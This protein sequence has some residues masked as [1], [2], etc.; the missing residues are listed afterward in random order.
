VI[1]GN[2]V[3]LAPVDAALLV[4][5]LEIVG[6]GRRDLAVDAGR[7]AERRGLADLD[8]GIGD[9]RHCGLLRQRREGG[10]G[11]QQRQGGSD[12][13]P[14]LHLGLP[15]FFVPARLW[16]LAAIGRA[17]RAARPGRSLGQQDVFLAVEPREPHGLERAIVGRAGVHRDA[18]QQHGEADVVHVGGGLHDVLARQVV[19]GILQHPYEGFGHVVAVPGGGV[20]DLV[21]GGVFLVPGVERLHA[22]IIL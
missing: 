2:E 13:R 5:H 16:T 9:A 10:G 20:G 21:L 22:G 17:A 8:L 14:F 1:E 15:W 3:D 4:Y 19:A 11:Q 18:R 12:R 6:L 7:P